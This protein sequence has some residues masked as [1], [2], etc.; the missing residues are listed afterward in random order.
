MTISALSQYAAI[1]FA[2][3]AAACWFRSATIELPPTGDE[4]WKGKGP[5]HAALVKQSQWNARA[6]ICAA[7]AAIIQAISLA[8][9]I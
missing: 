2:L 9:V 3:A 5:F 8:G 4:P 6:A 7:L 1:G